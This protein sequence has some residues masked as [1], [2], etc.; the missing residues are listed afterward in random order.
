[1]SAP[2]AIAPPSLPD[3]RGRFGAA[4]GAVAGH[5]R[6]QFSHMAELQANA[7]PDTISTPRR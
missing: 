2:T 3:A 4:L 5:I 7:S 6:G 1:M